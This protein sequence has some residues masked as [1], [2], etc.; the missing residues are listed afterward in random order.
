MVT[1]WLGYIAA[2]AKYSIDRVNMGNNMLVVTSYY[3]EVIY[4]NTVILYSKLIVVI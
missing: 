1:V 4:S 3:H 2:Y